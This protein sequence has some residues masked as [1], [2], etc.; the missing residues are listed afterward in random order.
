MA[1]L[2][3]KVLHRVDA[4][5]GIKTALQLGDFKRGDYDQITSI[6]GIADALREIDRHFAPCLPHTYS[7]WDRKGRGAAQ[8]LSIYGVD[9]DQNVAVYQIRLA[10][11]DRTSWFM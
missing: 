4:W 7:E 10:Q 2:D 6:G 8:S 3:D 5:A 1:S 9:L 11:R